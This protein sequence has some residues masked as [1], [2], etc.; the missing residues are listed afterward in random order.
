VRVPKPPRKL[1][2]IDVDKFVDPDLQHNKREREEKDA[3]RQSSQI[4]TDALCG[5]T[6]SETEFSDFGN[7]LY[8][9]KR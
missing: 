2:Q 3:G 7:M 5:N 6:S 4:M 1:E 9:S 8:M